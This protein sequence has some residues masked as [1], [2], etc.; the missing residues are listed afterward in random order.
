MAE[1]QEGRKPVGLAAGLDDFAPT[2]TATPAAKPA[3]SRPVPAPA[4]SG[5]E[6]SESA[7]R[8]VSNR[9]GFTSR[10][11]RR[12]NR[13]AQLNIKV[14]EETYQ[15]FAGWADAEGLAGE[16]LLMAALD[17]LGEKRGG[18]GD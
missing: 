17:A 1:Q 3:P 7:L 9:Q 10:H 16:E 5:G 2:P 14:S 6:I 18:E 11:R 12:S 15:R 13:T 8:R 4:P